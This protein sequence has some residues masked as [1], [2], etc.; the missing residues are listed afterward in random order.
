MTRL[1]FMFLL[2]STVPFLQAKQTRNRPRKTVVDSIPKAGTHVVTRLIQLLWEGQDIKFMVNNEDYGRIS[3]EEAEAVFPGESIIVSHAYPN[4]YNTSIL[5]KHN[6]YAIFIIRDPRD[7]IVSMANWMRNAPKHVFKYAYEKYSVDRL[8]TALIKFE[9]DLNPYQHIFQHK[10]ELNELK[11]VHNITDFYQLYLPWQK[12]PRVYVTRFEKLIG[13]QGGGTLDEQI[14][15]I[16]NIAN[17]IGCSISHDKASKIAKNLFHEKEV[18]FFKGQIGAWKTNFSQ[19]HKNIF[20]AVAG[21][22][23]VTLGYEKDLNW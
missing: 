6:L 14:T 20:K 8:I 19:R 22:L 23:L 4:K 9:K 15:E 2:V 16:M 13:E 5:E 21:N 1:I 12:N 10:S 18:T 7:Q 17:H 3:T 11:S